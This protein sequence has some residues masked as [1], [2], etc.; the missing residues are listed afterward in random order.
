MPFKSQSETCRAIIRRC[1]ARPLNTSRDDHEGAWAGSGNRGAFD[2][3]GGLAPRLL[4]L[5][6]NHPPLSTFS[7]S[8]SISLSPVTSSE[9]FSIYLR[10]PEEKGGGHPAK[11][12]RGL[13]PSSP[14]PSLP[15]RGKLSS[16]DRPWPL[17]PPMGERKQGPPPGSA[18][19]GGR[20]KRWVWQRG[21]FT[22]GGGLAANYNY[23]GGDPSHRSHMIRNIPP[24]IDHP[25]TTEIYDPFCLSNFIKLASSEP[26]DRPFGFQT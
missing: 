20:F 6:T 23:I 8:F 9:F 24:P 10:A 21:P 11:G 25:D 19:W 17:T 7:A 16:R 1:C 4:T 12:T 26:F 2:Q 5:S 15:E 18:K 14:P 22:G 13:T 3:E